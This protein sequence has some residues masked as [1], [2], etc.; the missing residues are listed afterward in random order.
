MVA[1]LVWLGE[2]EIRIH[3]KQH[4]GK[5]ERFEWRDYRVC[6]LYSLED[7]QQRHKDELEL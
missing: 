4:P 1:D 5:F 2:K 7:S 3:E 6:I